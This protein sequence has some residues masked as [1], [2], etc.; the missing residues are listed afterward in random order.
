L[1][2]NLKGLAANLSATDLHHAVR[3][4][5]I[6]V[7]QEMP[8]AEVIASGFRLLQT[9]LAQAIASA[10]SLH[11]MNKS[12]DDKEAIPVS[13]SLIREVGE[14]LR[15]IVIDCDINELEEVKSVLPAGCE[16]A[17]KIQECAEEYDMD[18]LLEIAIEMANYKG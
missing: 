18:N 8:D 7:K 10:K 17:K 12:V 3:S 5:E 4:L 16:Y 2:H 9:T 11:T 13:P 1:I 6:A 14:K 15:Q